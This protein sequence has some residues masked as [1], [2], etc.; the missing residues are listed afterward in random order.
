MGIECEV[1]K[2]FFLNYGLRNFIIDKN[3]RR[4]DVQNKGNLDFRIG[5]GF[6]NLFDLFGKLIDEIEEMF[7]DIYYEEEGENGEE[8]EYGDEI[9]YDLLDLKMLM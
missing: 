6:D 9:F 4:F 8:E 2:I 5:S 7:F 3:V 1:I